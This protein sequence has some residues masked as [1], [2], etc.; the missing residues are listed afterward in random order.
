MT[1]GNTIDFG[2]LSITG[3]YI[4]GMSNGHGGLGIMSELRINNITDT[5]GS[6]GQLL[7][8]YQ[9]SHQHHTWSC[10]VKQQ[11]CVVEEEEEY[12][13]EQHNPSPKCHGFC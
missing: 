1:T 13:L 12:L 7:L 3:Y 11:K 5:A 6:S 8:V 4:T 10:Q 2:D 9:Q